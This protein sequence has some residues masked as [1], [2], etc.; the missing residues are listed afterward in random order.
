MSS[1]VPASRSRLLELLM[2][3]VQ[4]RFRTDV[5]V[6]DPEDPIFGLGTCDITGCERTRLYIKTGLCERHR[7]R[8]T[9]AGKPELA[10][11]IA[12]QK[13]DHRRGVEA[14]CAVEGCN[15]VGHC[16]KLCMRH[17]GLYTKAKTGADPTTWAAEHLYTVVAGGEVD[18]RADDCP[19]WSDYLGIRL[20]K[21]HYRRWTDAGRPEDLDGFLALKSAYAT[22]AP[23]KLDMSD[24]PRQIRLELGLGLQRR[25]E[26]GTR[27]TKLIPIRRALTLIRETQVSSILDL[28][29]A[30]WRTHAT[31]PSG[32]TSSSALTF[33]LDI[34]YHLE[35]LLAGGIWEREYDRD[36]WDLRRLTNKPQR[37]SRYLH[38]DRIPQ[39]WIRALGKRWARQV[40]SH[41]TSNSALADK[42]RYLGDFAA[43]A[44]GRT[45]GCTEPEML[46][47]DLLESWYA[48]MEAAGD[49]I[50]LRRTKISALSVF[51]ATNHRYGWEERIPRTAIVVPGDSPKRR[52]PAPR[53]IDELV[54]RQI[55]DEKNLARF[56]ERHAGQL[57]MRIMIACGLRSKDTLLMPIECVVRDIAGAPYLAWVNTKV[58]ERVA[59]FPITEKLAERI[60]VQAHAVRERF[61]RGCPWLFPGENDNPLGDRPVPRRTFTG[62]LEAYLRDIELV[63]ENGNRT[64]VTTHQFRHTLGTRLINA[65]VPQHVVQTLLDHMSPAMTAVY[66]RLHDTTIREHWERATLTVNA[67]GEIVKVEESDPLSNAVWSR[68]SLG[69]AKQTLPNGYC[70]LPL[71][72]DCE[73]ANP[74]LTC[75]M[76]LT[77]PEFLPQHQE[78]RGRTL[79]IIESAKSAGH[80]RIAEKNQ[81][82]LENLDKI[83]TACESCE[84][85]EVVFGGKVASLDA[86]S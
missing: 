13:P 42:V 59:F 17:W 49:G 20:C 57:V 1:A 75:P 77:T 37:T 31:G 45:D 16:N 85:D 28:D 41:G 73:H 8:W 65:N 29:E 67:E 36:V 40:F 70:G 69:R 56:P 53:F 7:D 10:A 2:Q 74:C 50:I 64:R 61:P 3:T 60:A 63:D 14:V 39:P 48:H 83:I 24:L 5:F 84:D 23:P 81:K 35:V 80:A 46:T 26:E 58:G 33:L 6:A 79:T 47:R 4:P 9:A 44:A 54:M 15:R 43:Y 27:N 52:P 51:L 25:L 30:A 38:F 72:R 18:C 86:A 11:W 82:I 34:H 19:R 22:Y 21:V 55:E 68:I 71:I 66:A 62:Q 32:K 76:F 12:Q 78:Q